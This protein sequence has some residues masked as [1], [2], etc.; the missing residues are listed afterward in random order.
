MFFMGYCAGAISAPQLWTQKPRYFSGV[1]TATVRW[2]CLF[3]LAGV[4]WFICVRENKKRVAEE[5][6]DTEGTFYHSGEDITD[7]Q[8]KSFRYR[9]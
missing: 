8:D 1:L 3:A 9:I 2:C 5:N 6:L 4:Y 7:K